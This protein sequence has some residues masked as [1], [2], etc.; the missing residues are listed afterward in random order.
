MDI[1]KAY[2]RRSLFWIIF[3]ISFLCMLVGSAFHFAMSVVSE[4]VLLLFVAQANAKLP[5]TKAFIDQVSMITD[6]LKVWF[7]PIS[8]GVFFLVGLF[9]W[10]FLYRSFSNLIKEA[11]LESKKKGAEPVKKTSVNVDKKEKKE[12]DTRLF[13]HLMSAL[14]REGRLMD[15][16]SEDLDE[17]E[18]EQIGAA[19]RS[20]HDNCRK[21]VAKYLTSKAVINEEEGD[22]ITVQPDFD[23]GT[24]KLTGNVTGEPPFKGVV[25]HRGWKVARIDLPTLSGSRD[26]N[27][28]APA[29]V[30]I[31]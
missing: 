16:F 22:E 8:T 11:D 26:P 5:E 23:P 2:S 31:L 25:R 14:Q 27:I 28:I 9:L 29:E 4:K 30:E 20:I 12:D 6:V 21:A 19:V 7:V 10:F 17:Y 18:D 15:F 13:L 3:P 1:I 24:I